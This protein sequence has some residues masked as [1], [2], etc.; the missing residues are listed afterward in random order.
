ML[1]TDNADLAERLRLLRSHGM[2]TLTWDRHRGHASSYDVIRPGFNYRLDELHAATGL[3]QLR[4]LP[5]ENAA[6][7]RIAA[8]YRERI[9]GSDGLTMA[10]SDRLGD[11]SAHHLAVALVPEDVSRDDIRAELGRRRIQT[12][13]HYP[14]IHEFS[15]YRGTGRSRGLPRTENAA[16]RAVTLPLF[17]HMTDAQVELVIDALMDAVGRS[18]RAAAGEARLG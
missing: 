17:A 6:R 18:S 3:V 11:Q 5:E 1:V 2:T 14:P 13:L 12:S 4:K 8:R 15:A 9:T 16:G 10:F 7:A